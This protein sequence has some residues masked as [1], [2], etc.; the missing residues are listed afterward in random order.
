L[1]SLVVAV[2]A[3]GVILTLTVVAEGRAAC[4]TPPALALRV[5]SLAQLRLA[6]VGVVA[7]IRVVVAAV[8]RPSTGFQL[9]AVVAAAFGAPQQTQLL[10]VQV[11]AAK[12]WGTLAVQRVLPDK[13]TAAG[14]VELVGVKIR[15]TVV[16]V[17]VAR[18]AQGGLPV[19]RVS[20]AAL[21]ALGETTLLLTRFAVAAALVLVVAV[22]DRL[23][24]A[25]EGLPQQSQTLA[26]VGVVPLMVVAV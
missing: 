21:V 17:V 8:T 3:L 1:F 13:V 10:A 25:A 11:A 19:C 4:S 12:L 15:Q 14:Q 16:V 24:V 22:L 9:V 2:A 7:I 6:A 23:L 5:V 18:V 26:V 20:S